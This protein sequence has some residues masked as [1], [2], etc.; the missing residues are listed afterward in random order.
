MRTLFRGLPAIPAR[1][2]YTG[3]PG[4]GS[5]PPQISMGPFDSQQ[6]E[7]IL[8]VLHDLEITIVPHAASLGRSTSVTGEFPGAHLAENAGPL[9]QISS[10]ALAPR[11]YK[12]AQ[13]RLTR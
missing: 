4:P 9:I 8:D 3:I 13:A 5:T 7:L 2:T 11:E 10:S 12:G 6:P 1:L